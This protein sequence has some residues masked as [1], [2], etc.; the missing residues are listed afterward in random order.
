MWSEFNNRIFSLACKTSIVTDDDKN[1][2][3]D[4]FRWLRN[5]S[6]DS[7]DI[8]KQNLLDNGLI[9]ICL[10]Y[11]EDYFREDNLSRSIILQFLSNF[12]MNN[13][14]VQ[15]Q[16]FK[17]FHKKI[18]VT[19]LSSNDAKLLNTS[20]MILYTLSINNNE[21]RVQV[22]QDDE[23]I[24]EVF[25]KWEKAELE[26]CKI[27]L[28]SIF[29]NSKD[30]FIIY[31]NICSQTQSDL[32]EILCIWL[33]HYEE[34][35]SIDVIDTIGKKLF[36]EITY[37]DEVKNSVLNILAKSSSIS[38]FKSKFD[39]DP[40]F[41]K[42]IIDLLKYVHERSKNNNEFSEV[43]NLSTLFSGSEIISHSRFC[44]KSDIIRLISNICHNNLDNQN[45][46]RTEHV[47]PIL[48]ECCSFDA[49]NPLMREWSIVA[50]R[51]ILNGN[52]NNQTFV[53][54]IDAIGPIDQNSKIAF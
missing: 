32:L 8:N 45:M 30:F 29:S 33:E 25:K 24:K 40:Q 31:K 22:L 49:K 26:Y 10:W 38:K 12:S 51:N 17:G 37:F 28:D 52:L 41:L 48:L 19:F 36:M 46:I 6:S 21:L 34:E 3:T 14:N 1:Y 4:T 5:N 43:K 39:N 53:A 9:K 54:N 15:E 18:R 11:F 13:K 7:N 2:I 35:V 16:I 20:I 27:F 23:L 44:F 42:K 50:L 47:I